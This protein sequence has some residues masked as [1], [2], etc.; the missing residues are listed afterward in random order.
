M[1][2]KWDPGLLKA[3]ILMKFGC[4]I[5]IHSKYV[6]FLLV[7]KYQYS[8]YHFKWCLYKLLTDLY[9][10][11]SE[12]KKIMNSFHL[13][14]WFQKHPS[15]YTLVQTCWL[16]VQSSGSHLATGFSLYGVVGTSTT[17]L[18]WPFIPLWTVSV[19]AYFESFSSK[20]LSDDELSKCPSHHWLLPLWYPVR[21]HSWGIHL[22]LVEYDSLWQYFHDL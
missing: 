3:H 17:L 9:C 2:L 11:E 22:V 10:D 15:F 1:L 4:C 18:K 7:P 20:V 14:S 16:Y 12:V 13:L 6:Q 21:L 5:P 8:L 19:P